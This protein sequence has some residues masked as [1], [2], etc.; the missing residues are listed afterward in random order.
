MDEAALEEI[1]RLPVAQQLPKLLESLSENVKVVEDLKAKIQQLESNPPEAGTSNAVGN[2]LGA[3]ILAK[4]TKSYT[5]KV[6]TPTMSAGMNYS[7]YRFSVEC[8]Q[9][10]VDIPKK[11]Q[12]TLLVNSLPD[13]DY[14]GGLKEIVAKR[15]GWEKIQC[16]EGVENVLNELDKIIRSPDFVRLMQWQ[17]KWGDLQ[18]GTNSFEKH[19]LTLRQ[20][21]RDAAEDFNLEVPAKMICSKMLLSCSAVQPENI[22]NITANIE[23]AG[24]DTDI[25][26]QVEKRLKQYCSTV[27]Q[28]GS[29]QVGGDNKILFVERDVFGDIIEEQG[30]SS[31]QQGDINDVLLG[32]RGNKFRGKGQAAWDEK[33]KRCMEQ[34]LCF[35]CEKPIAVAGHKSAEC[36]ITI[37][38]KAEYEARRKRK[39]GGQDGPGTAPYNQGVIPKKAQVNFTSRIRNPEMSGEVLNVKTALQRT[40]G[41]PSSCSVE[42]SLLQL[43]NL[44]T[45]NHPREDESLF[46]EDEMESEIK[47]K[48]RKKMKKD[49]RNCWLT[50]TVEEEQ[51]SGQ[52]VEQVPL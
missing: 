8:W 14:Y 12:A 20:L 41:N 9:K 35:G 30:S 45:D 3:Q 46:E 27:Q 18:Q 43:P 50:S 32:D 47:K 7:K 33:K 36:P 2:D 31:G 13:N 49:T 4:I 24:D 11:D 40:S 16:N 38:K 22:G 28:L 42:D 17:R 39:A 51:P 44:D 48:K 6:N 10:G 29:R 5:Q 1:K 19:M 34:N 26:V 23:L 25:D 37:A 15:L 21:V 52:W